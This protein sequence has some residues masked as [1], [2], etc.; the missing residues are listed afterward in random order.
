MSAN[1]QKEKRWSFALYWVEAL[2]W[3]STAMILLGNGAQLDLNRG[4]GWDSLE[5]TQSCSED[6]PL[7]F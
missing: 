1:L 5:L 3:V 6:T 4:S 7:F 2:F